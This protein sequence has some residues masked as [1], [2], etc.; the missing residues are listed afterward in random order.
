MK[1]FATQL[2]KSTAAYKTIEKFSAHSPYISASKGHVSISFEG[3]AH[4]IHYTK[5]TVGNEE[6]YA[7]MAITDMGGDK[8]ITV[9]VSV[10]NT[11]TGKESYIIESLLYI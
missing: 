1:S 7:S 8:S 9:L 2:N 6:F 10:R 5:V 4:G 11:D 3:Q